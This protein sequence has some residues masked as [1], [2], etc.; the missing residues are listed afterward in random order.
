MV[1]YQADRRHRPMRS[2]K[3]LTKYTPITMS[4]RVGLALTAR[5]MKIYI[6]FEGVAS[7]KLKYLPRP[8]VR[9]RSIH[10]CELRSNPSHD[11]VPVTLMGYGPCPGAQKYGPLLTMAMLEEDI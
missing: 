11:P 8:L 9:H 6:F 4:N 2:N 1:K 10:A 3:S 5:N 7:E